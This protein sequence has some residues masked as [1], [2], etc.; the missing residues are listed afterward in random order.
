MHGQLL[1]ILADG[2]NCSHFALIGLVCGVN[3]LCCKFLIIY[4]HLCVLYSHK[5][6]QMYSYSEPICF[7]PG[8]RNLRY[9]LNRHLNNVSINIKQYYIRN[10][11]LS[12]NQQQQRF[13][14]GIASNTPLLDKVECNTIERERCVKSDYRIVR[15]RNYLN[16]NT[17]RQQR[18]SSSLEISTA[19]NTRSSHSTDNPTPTHL[20]SVRNPLDYLA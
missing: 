19:A 2:W 6:S 3:A 12:M 15:G 1:Y 4:I 11:T 20:C 17:A 14:C 7:R 13:A 9:T 10:N 5:N 8:L 16:P 18:P